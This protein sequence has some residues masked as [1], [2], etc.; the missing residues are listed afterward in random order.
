MAVWKEKNELLV[1]L[2]LESRIA[3]LDADTLEAKGEF[4]AV[5]GVR[6]IAIDQAA[7]LLLCGSL[8]TGELEVIDLSNGK[9]RA[10]YY[11]GPW[12]R[13]IELLPDRGQAYI[14]SNGAIFEVKYK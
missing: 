7:N 13:T 2:P 8:A 12:L 6:S 4:K 5:F 11:L 9:R 3:R 1:T 10:R 14:S